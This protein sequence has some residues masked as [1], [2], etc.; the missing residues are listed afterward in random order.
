MFKAVFLGLFALAGTGAS[1]AQAAD[2]PARA[3]APDAFLMTAKGDGGWSIWCDYEQRG[4]G[5]VKREVAPDK[6][7]S[8]ALTIA[9]LNHGAC[10]YTGG[11]GPLTITIS[12]DAWAC[13]FKVATDAACEKIIARLDSGEFKLTRR[14]APR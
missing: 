10:H 6:N 2:A 13:P 3:T 7:H 11:S 8:G 14:S 9:Q 1:A 4:A 5:D 12:G